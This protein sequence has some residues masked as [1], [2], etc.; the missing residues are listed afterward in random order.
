M[1]VRITWKLLCG[2]S[3]VLYALYSTSPQGGCTSVPCQSVTSVLS[4]E[5]IMLPACSSSHLPCSLLYQVNTDL[6]INDVVIFLHRVQFCVA[7]DG[8][9]PMFSL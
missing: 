2:H 6:V 7:A 1:F 4:Q 9:F 5:P 3:V 8:K